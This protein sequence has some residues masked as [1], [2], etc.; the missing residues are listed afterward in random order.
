MP[1]TPK[2][3]QKQKGFHV[4]KNKGCA[5]SLILYNRQAR[6]RGSAGRAQPCQGW[7]RGFEPRRPLHL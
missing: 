3:S 4:C 7:G 1:P 5:G 6:G 2:N